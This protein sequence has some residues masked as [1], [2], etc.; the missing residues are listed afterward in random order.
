MAT[1]WSYKRLNK[2]YT[3]KNKKCLAVAQRYIQYFPDKAAPY[4]F[5]AIVY[6]DMAK[7]SQSPRV[8][9]STMSKALGYAKKFELKNDAELMDIVDWDLKL[10]EMSKETNSIIALLDADHLKKLGNRLEKK[11]EKLEGADLGLYANANLEETSDVKVVD[12][13][14]TEVAEVSMREATK[15]INGQYFGLPSG[16]ERIPSYNEVNEQEMLNL[17]NAERKAKG[18]GPLVWKESLANAARYHANDMATQDYFNHSSKDRKN[19][20]LVNAAGTF[21]RIRQ[22]H[23]SSFANSENIAAGNESAKSTYIQWYESPGHY[24]NMFNPSSQNVGIGVCY[25]PSSTFGYYWVFC[26][27]L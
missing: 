13:S 11:C 7:K 25:D 4:Y 18:M 17:V 19:G 8:K 12:L 1:D 3:S 23:T 21:D 26:T 20:K 2:L 16:S 27:A 10:E 24:E 14:N 15:S 6:K 9:Y 5:A 22:F